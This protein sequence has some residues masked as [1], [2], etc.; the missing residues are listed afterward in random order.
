MFISSDEKLISVFVESLYLH[1][2]VLHSFCL[3]I[4]LIKFWV[5]LIRVFP[6]PP[7]FF[8]LNVA[9]KWKCSAV[10]EVASPV[11]CETTGDG[12]A[13]LSSLVWGLGTGTYQEEA[14]GGSVLCADV[15]YCSS[16]K[17]AASHRP[18]YVLPCRPGAHQSC[19]N[20]ILSG[21]LVYSYSSWYIFFTLGHFQLS[22]KSRPL[23]L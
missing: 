7:F 3:F 21:I 14:T 8:K 13:V 18:E 20:Q 23:P 4:Y 10:W 15:P 19:Q 2:V 17:E 12:C 5:C 6:S 11:A 16:L 9:G 1:V 22:S